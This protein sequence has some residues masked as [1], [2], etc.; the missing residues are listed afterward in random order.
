MPDRVAGSGETGQG[1]GNEERKTN[2]QAEIP[3]Q[4]TTRRN[5]RLDKLDLLRQSYENSKRGLPSHF[6]NGVLVE[7]DHPEAED[8]A[9]PKQ[10]VLKSKEA[11]ANQRKLE[12]GEM[13]HRRL[14]QTQSEVMF[15]NFRFHLDMSNFDSSTVVSDAVKQFW[16]D[17]IFRPAADWFSKVLRVKRVPGNLQLDRICARIWSTSG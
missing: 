4:E 13:Q 5:P 16:K 12:S 8:S 17:E 2:L 10:P 15:E 14:S 1:A 11:A 6:K 3:L 9:A 7:G